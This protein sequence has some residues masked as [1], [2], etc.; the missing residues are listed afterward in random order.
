M[1]N[2][3][4]K[5]QLFVIFLL[6]LRIPQKNIIR[7]SIFETVKKKEPFLLFLQL[8]LKKYIMT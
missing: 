6:L 3:A 1:F 4:A 5:V 7:V 2:N 8:L